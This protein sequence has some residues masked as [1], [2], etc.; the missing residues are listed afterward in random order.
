MKKYT[1]IAIFLSMN[2]I[3]DMVYKIDN[4]EDE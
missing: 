3:T 4:E 2:N 1:F